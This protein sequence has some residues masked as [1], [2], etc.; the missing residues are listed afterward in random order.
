M[1]TPRTADG[2]RLGVALLRVS[3]DLQYQSGG[4]IENQRNRIEFLAKRERIAIVR[5]FE[6]HFSGR[7]FNR[8][9]IENMIEFL[10][11][12]PAI[13]VVI[14]GD[15]DR[16]TRG[17]AG[18]YLTLKDR[19]K[20]LN[21]DLLDATGIIQPERNKLEHTG[22]AYPWSVE[23]PSRMAE[24]IMA[25]NAR[26]EG[27]TILTRV[28]DQEIN[29]TQQ[30]YHCRQAPFGYRLEKVMTPEG[31][32][33]PTLQP[34][35]IEGKWIIRAFKYKAAGLLGDTAICEKLNAQ[36]FKTRPMNVHDPHTRRIIGQ[37]GLN[38]I[39]PSL[40]QRY[41]ANPIYAGIKV[42]K[43]THNQPVPMV[44][45]PLISIGLFNA[46]SGGRLV[47]EPLENPN[48]YRLVENRKEYQCR[49]HNPEF[50]L[51]RLVLCPTCGKPLHAS[52][53]KGKY[54]KF[55]YFHCRRHKPS[56]SVSQKVFEE[57]VATC[58]KSLTGKPGF[59]PLLR[60]IVREIWLEKND[61]AETE[62]QDVAANRNA[63]LTQQENLVNKVAMTSSPI[64]LKKLEE[65]IEALEDERIKL[66]EQAATPPL[67]RD[68]IFAFFEIAKQ[69]FEHPH[70]F[71]QNALTERQIERAW[72]IIFAQKPTYEDL[73]L[74]TPDLTL[75]Y[76]LNRDFDGKKSQVVHQLKS[77]S[78]TFEKEIRSAL[79]AFYPL[80]LPSAIKQDDDPDDSLPAL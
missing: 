5:A 29:L 18:T 53:S 20:T 47:I 17:G 36:G 61:E 24:V 70:E 51:R 67:E 49:R 56:F 41:I 1:Q 64:L 71:V 11:R 19:L 14:F 12:H 69:A 66:D 28:I 10:R 34:D 55:G 59:L 39:T 46:A 65:Q 6:E 35:P 32:K 40:L 73:Q 9:V 48:T 74:R 78:N 54:Q 80:G 21:V 16:M 43:W 38:P 62:I 44:G 7:A 57:T 75:I 2:T 26:T 25:E 60:E 4:G 68:E 33:R 23:S 37:K 45:K 3:T 77:N 79:S 58:L 50:L 52:K 63:I 42:E 72:S 22:F 15:I 13:S 76:R 31:K 30:G 27:S 8:Q